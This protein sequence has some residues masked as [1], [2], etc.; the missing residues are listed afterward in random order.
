MDRRWNAR[1]FDSM[2]AGV[3]YESAPLLSFDFFY[4][5]DCQF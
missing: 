4:H 2:S 3:C 5:R 1:E